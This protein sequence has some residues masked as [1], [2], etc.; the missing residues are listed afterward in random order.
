[1]RNTLDAC[2]ALHCAYLR[3]GNV[4]K[5]KIKFFEILPAIF[6]YPYVKDDLVMMILPSK[7]EAGRI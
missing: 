7:Q 5:W 6:P 2:I 4:L 3:N 1:M